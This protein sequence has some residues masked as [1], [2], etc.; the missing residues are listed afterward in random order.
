[1]VRSEENEIV[2]LYCGSR[3]ISL[4]EATGKEPNALPV[5]AATPTG[6][7]ILVRSCLMLLAAATDEICKGGEVDVF[8]PVKRLLLFRDII[9]Y[10]PIDM[11]ICERRT[12]MKPR[13]AVLFDIRTIAALLALIFSL[14]ALISSYHY[15]YKNTPDYAFNRII[16]SADAKDK[17]AF[18]KAVND[19]AL[20]FAIYDN[21]AQRRDGNTVSAILKVT[22]LSSRESFA[23]DLH[24]LLSDSIDGNVPANSDSLKSDDLKDTLRNFGFIVP[25][26]GWHYDSHDF[27]HAVD[28][29]TALLTVYWYNDALQASIP[30]TLIMKRIN[31]TWTVAD[32]DDSTAFLS[33]IHDASMTALALSNDD[34]SKRME[35][36]VHIENIQSSLVTDDN[37]NTFLRLDYTPVYPQGTSDIESIVCDFTLK[38]TQDDAVLYTTRLHVPLYKSGT[39]LTARF[40][41]N[42]LIPSQKTLRDLP[43]LDN[44]STVFQPVSIQLKNGTVLSLK[45]TL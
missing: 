3:F 7:K 30:C 34:V 40:P 12:P 15:I 5:Y 42:G 16:T 38:R 1:M 33:R 2:G 13:D 8:Y 10:Y 27:S 45:D 19:K 31:G 37:D 21:A 39:S 41:L 25:V 29:S 20:A 17:S 36:Y 14:A 4:R 23:E 28:D 18:F 9:R 6:N 32:L 11:S 43:S 22:G 26:T 35:R 24:T 44:T